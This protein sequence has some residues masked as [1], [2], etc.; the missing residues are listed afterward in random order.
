ML[1][2]HPIE[3][4]DPEAGGLAEGERRMLAAHARIVRRR[5]ALIRRICRAYLRQI[6]DTGPATIDPVR[7]LIILPPGADPRC[8]GAAVRLLAEEHLIVSIGRQKSNRPEAHGRKIDIWS[9]TDRAAALDWLTSHPELPDE[10]EQLLFDD[11]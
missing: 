2:S 10:P 9:V 5:P 1:D 3:P 8:F 11:F 7:D 6:L 4:G